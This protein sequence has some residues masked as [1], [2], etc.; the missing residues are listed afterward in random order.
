MEPKEIET[1]DSEI[2]TEAPADTGEVT[3]TVD[4][5][6]R[7]VAE[8]DE[9]RAKNAKLYARLQKEKTSKPLEKATIIKETPEVS[10]EIQ[11]LKL[12]VDYDIK[13]PEAI[14]FVMK[15]GGEEALKNPYIKQTIDNMLTQK[16]A[17]QAQVAEETQKSDFERKVSK[18]Q[19]KAMSVEELEKLLPHA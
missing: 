4:D 7:V 14:D 6:N 10:Q 2:V 18:D 3:L 15:N 5:Y 12:K 1:T 13:D 16:R 8:R 17:E 11:R 19:M 9:E